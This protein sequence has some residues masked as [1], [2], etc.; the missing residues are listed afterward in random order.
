VNFPQGGGIGFPPSEV[1]ATTVVISTATSGST[2]IFVYNG[3]PGSG[4]PP[5]FSI[6]APGVTAD[7]FGNP[8][9]AVFSINGSAGQSILFNIIG[10]VAKELFI[11]GDAIEQTAANIA[12]GIVGAG[13]TR[14]LELVFSGPQANVVGS[15]DWVQM[16]WQSGNG[17]ATIP[18]AGDFIYIDNTA[19]GHLYAFWNHSGF[20][21]QTGTI[22]APQPGIVPAVPESWHAMTLD[23]GWTTL[24]GHSP[25]SYQ[26]LPDGNVQISGFAQHASFSGL[27]TLT[28]GTPIPAAYRPFNPQSVDGI[29]A[30]TGKIVVNSLG[31]VETSGYPA[32]SVQVEFN[33]IYPVNL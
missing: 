8:V 9:T 21:I 17:G 24:A 10:G 1:L 23:G 3:T 29:G 4:N 31:I 7:P 19:T 32:A 25:P 13:V 6:V 20:I 27:V 26:M 33:G 12:S 16:V 11:T 28:S 2:G 22:T 15:T 5:I 30:G 14:Q 18:A